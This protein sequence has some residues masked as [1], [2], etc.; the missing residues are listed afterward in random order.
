[1]GRIKSACEALAKKHRLIKAIWI[2][3][4]A[5]R[6]EKTPFD[7]DMLLLYDD[8]RRI[9]EAELN[10]M[11]RDVSRVEQ[12]LREKKLNVH[13]QS[14]K[15]L[16]LWWDML[17][18]GNP[19]AYTAMRDAL[20]IYD[21]AGY[22]EPL[23]ILLKEGRLAGSKE[24]AEEL[25]GKAPKKLELAR[26]IFLEEIITDL[27]GAM[28]EASHAVLM[29][30][31]VAPPAA[32]NVRTELRERFV[33]SGLLEE[34]WV[35]DYEDFF[36]FTSKIEHGEVTRVTGE[37]IDRRLERVANFIHRLELLFTAL[38]EKKR[39]A[40]VERAHS[41][42]FNAARDALKKVAKTAPKSHEQVIEN[43]KTHFIDT[44]L[45]A[46]EHLQ[47][48][49]KVHMA[50]RAAEAGKILELPEKDVYESEVYA[51]NLA[52][53]LGRAVKEKWAVK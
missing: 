51:R 10:E 12:N 38:D 40:I 47:V 31:G 24:A 29:F 42:A 20:V 41:T 16:S 45:V 28:T 23:Q 7:I 13:F 1:M 26:R 44:G 11:K 35:R 49:R 46:P 2:F 15:P 8:T 3:G 27:M 18:S 43:F 32:K 19:L 34:S 25:L 5:A 36:D 53:V 21:P 6:E 4:S 33:K 50:K 52:V 9:A 22:V 14:P 37:E 30:A 17:R 39:R 48:L